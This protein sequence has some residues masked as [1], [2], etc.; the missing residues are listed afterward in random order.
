MGKPSKGDE[1][2]TRPMPLKVSVSGLA[3]WRA[4]AER[5]GVTFAEWA[6]AALDRAAGGGE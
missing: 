2:L 6:R 5:E 3:R 4:A 1:A